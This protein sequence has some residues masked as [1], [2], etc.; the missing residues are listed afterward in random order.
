MYTIRE[1]EIYVSEIAQF[2]NCGFVGPDFIVSRPSSIDNLTEFSVVYVEEPDN[3]TV[4]RI[5]STAHTLIIARSPLPATNSALIITPNPKLAF[6]QVLREFFMELSL[7][8]I[9]PTA[10]VS[11]HAKL[12]T[13]VTIGEFC[14]I[15]P[16]V[17]VENGTEILSGVV[18][19]GK[20]RIGKN[21]LIKN[22]AVIG[23][24]GYGFVFDE[25]GNPVHFPQFGR[26]I[27]GNDVWI[28]A[29]TTIERATFQ[30]TVVSDGVKIDDLV[31]IGNGCH[32][33]ANTMITAGTV[34]SESVTIGPN[35]WLMPNV[36]VRNNIMIG[37]Q[38]TIGIGSVVVRDLPANATFVGNPARLVKK[39]KP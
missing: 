14:V 21:C 27:I 37:A 34:L 26:I 7:P 3:Q 20:V 10:Q 15:G 5:T 38:A 16:E 18:V 39:N 25:S 23:S 28:G 13:N 1:Q 36:S 29:N 17:E 22:R 19:T 9:H 8:G 33:G 11:S 31:H 32:I 35:C 2:L 6:V 24:E 4:A 30:D 12:A